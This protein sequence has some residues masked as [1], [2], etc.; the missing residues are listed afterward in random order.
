[1]L[2]TVLGSQ[3]RTDGMPAK[4]DQLR[5][6]VPTS[7]LEAL[8]GSKGIIQGADKPLYLLEECG[9]FFSAISVG[10]TLLRE[11]IR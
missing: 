6:Q 8:R 5:Q 2:V 7:A 1:M 11:R 10:G 3:Q 4:A 9:V